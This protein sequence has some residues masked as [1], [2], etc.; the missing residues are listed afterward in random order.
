MAKAQDQASITG[1]VADSTGAVIPNVTVTL[2]N[3]LTGAKYTAKTDR[4]GSYRF[5]S[6]PASTGYTETFSCDGFSSEQITGINLA[7]GQ[8][9]T[10]SAQLKPGK[11]VETVQ[12]SA[13]GETVTLNTTDATV[14]NSISIDQL[15]QLPVYNRTTGITTL[16][17]QQPGVDSNTGAV[18]G[19]R[20][21]QNS[22]TVDGL[23]VND[24]AAG[25]NFAIVGGAP[26]DSVEQFT[27]DVAGLSPD[28][29]T[30]GGGQFHLIT[31]SGSNKFHGN[32]NE[33]HRDTDTVANSWFNNLTGIARTP[34]IHNQF[35]GDVSGPI[36][37]DKL[38]FYFDYAASR[39]VQSST[40][41]RKV[42]LTA[43]R[44]GGLNYINNNSG[45][46]YSSTLI[47]QPSCITALTAAQLKALDPAGTGFDSSLI[48]F[49]NTRYPAANDTSY[50]DGVNTGGYRFTAPTPDNRTTYVGKVDYTIT[51]TQK[52]S[53]RF[54]IARRNATES[55]QEFKSDPQSHPYID[56]SYAYVINHTWN[57]GANKV[58]QFYY[59]D[60]IAKLNFPASYNP[61]GVNQYTF[62]GLDGPYTSGS[63][64]KRRI[65]IPVVRDDFSWQRGQHNF[66][67]GGT[68]K[69]IKTNSNL[70]SNFNYV[71]VG[72]AGNALTN[73]LDSTVR[74]SNI[75]VDPYQTAIDDYDSLFS[76]GLGVIGTTSANFNYDKN[77]KQVPQ[78][79]G[80]VR[81]YRFYQTEVYFGDTWKITA[82][83][84]LNYGLRYQYYSVP[85]ETHGEESVPQTDIPLSTFLADRIT[86]QNAG[87]TSTTGL[88]IYSYRLG[89]KANN[90]PNMYDPSYKD[91]APRIGFSYSPYANG[92]TVIRGS[93]GLQYDRTLIDAITFVQDQNSYLFYNSNTNQ[94][95][96]ST[97]DASLA[98]D[99]RI[100]SNL[101]YPTAD[102]PVA[103]AM[104]STYTPYVDSNGVPNGTANGEA[105][106]YIPKGLK[107]PYYLT[108]TFGVQQNLPGH[109]VLKVDY[110]GRFGRR[111][112]ANADANQ[113]I[114]VPDYSGKST[115]TMVQAFAN[116]TTQLRNGATYKTV[117]AQP[118]FE[119]NMGFYPS[120]KRT[121]AAT[122]YASTYLSRGDISDAIANELIPYAYNYFPG[123]WPTNIGIPGQFGT[124][125]YITNM[126]NSNYHGL[127][128]TV[129]K[130]LSQGLRA[131]FNY[132]LS[133]SIDNTSL[134]ANNNPLT[135][136]SPA[137]FI[138]D[139]M[140]TRACRG[141]SDFDVRQLITS[142]FNYDLPFGHQK[143]FAANAPRWLDEAI[144]NW[145]FSGLI[146]FRTG[147]PLTAYSDAYL[148]SYDNDDP[149]IYTGQRGQLKTSVNVDHTTNKVYMFAGGKTGANSALSLFRGPV[150]L[151]YGQRNYLR[152]P[153]S[154][155][156]DGALDK[157]FPV[158]KDQLKLKFQ[159]SA[160][161]LLNHPNFGGGGLHIISNAS[162][163]GQITGMDS[164][165]T[166]SGARVLQG[167]LRLE[168]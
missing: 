40:A 29:G 28:T 86:Q 49:I 12:V 32:V 156:L 147:L 10:Q 51:P 112:I 132:T 138:C 76:L 120:G 2:T 165:L 117:S 118:W 83:L 104:S 161:N 16:F 162:S 71:Y 53:G 92:K 35:G 81:A 11:N 97:V 141:D 113:V 166:T 124:N 146:A 123:F 137:G 65:P 59:G 148:A 42:P 13:S 62:E 47:N 102:I 58:N 57:I 129:D 96:S 155:D 93:A 50:G 55:L 68:F 100:G 159:A 149:A 37:H 143:A 136:S 14:G 44:N 27:G 89:G 7:V 78:G 88:P 60:N 116:V 105:N 19:A 72:E 31:K 122:Y 66:A 80:A 107:D 103:P 99:D 139:V 154:F 126:G 54:T 163:F 63:S 43:F 140:H 151:E 33:Y 67:F 22:V 79:A 74:P 9:R 85:W 64:Q 167:S 130:N 133:H 101:S 164:A 1:V 115:Q 125:E 135:Q 20:T 73:G 8:T 77:Q 150:G 91:F 21:D 90:G 75:L 168:F 157:T 48:S 82:K 69:F 109:V 70:V 145:S 111:L 24:I 94:F 142:N 127:L 38:F 23:D 106:L 4:T 17:V 52:L 6:I 158:V 144:G 153:K 56:R 95:G 160:F 26:V 114:D 84:T 25:T 119:D 61:T 108:V 128:V 46:T 87:N 110:S 5:V 39:I 41:E 134:T 15:N 3:T 152:S 36:K 30:G 34:Y 98:S 18:T 45:C 131:E 121:S